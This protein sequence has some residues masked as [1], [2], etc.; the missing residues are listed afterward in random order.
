[1][2]NL[3][4]TQSQKPQ[5][6]DSMDSLGGQIAKMMNNATRR[7]N[8][9]LKPLGY[10]INVQVDFCELLKDEDKQTLIKEN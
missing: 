10:C 5:E 8:K 1:M 3:E 7:A 9:L 2:E 6:S 4:Q